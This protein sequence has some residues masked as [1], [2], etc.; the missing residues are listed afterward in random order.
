M[1]L[2]QHLL[3]LVGAYLLLLFGALAFVSKITAALFLASSTTLPVLLISLILFDMRFFDATEKAGIARLVWLSIAFFYG[4][5]GQKWASDLINEI[6]K[7][8]PVCFGTSKMFVAVF[9]TP[10]TIYSSPLW[11]QLHGYS[12][13]I[14]LL[15]PLILILFI[16]FK[17]WKWFKLSYYVYFF[18]LL[19]LPS[20]F[21][22]NSYIA[23]LLP[24]VTEKLALWGDFNDNF[25]SKELKSEGASKVVFLGGNRILAY[26][27]NKGKEYK[28]S[29]R[30]LSIGE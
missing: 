30:E 8:D 18:F 19:C 2:R 16:A 26:F 4:W 13:Y 22:L 14:Y 15:W 29:I 23:T 27:P 20:I 28:Y 17:W 3:W 25:R 9:L 1:K 6:F 24:N 10:L 12:I 21:N 7:V 5:F 11:H